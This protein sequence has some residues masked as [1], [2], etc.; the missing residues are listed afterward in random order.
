M[1]AMQFM[2]LCAGLLMLAIAMTIVPLAVRADYDSN[3][4][5][6]VGFSRVFGVPG[7]VKAIRADGTLWQYSLGDTGGWVPATDGGDPV[8]A[9]P[10]VPIPVSQIAHFQYPFLVSKS[11][12]LWHYHPYDGWTTHGVLPPA[13]TIAVEGATVSDVKKK[14]RE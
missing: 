3:E 14:F 6:V 11:G 2:Y 5:H 13:G 12:E 4:V 1:R 9:T 8:V 10:P 7:L